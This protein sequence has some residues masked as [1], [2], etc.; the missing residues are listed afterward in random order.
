MFE[1]CKWKKLT[2]ELRRKNTEAPKFSRG[3]YSLLRKNFSSSPATMIL[4]ASDSSF[5][6]YKVDESVK[7]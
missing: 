4:L 1:S 7:K 6:T 5:L 3:F 2:K